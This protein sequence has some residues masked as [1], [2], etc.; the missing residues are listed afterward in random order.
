MTFIVHFKDGHRQ[1]YS[2]RYDEDIE[3]ERDAAW[4]DVYD[5]SPDA[6]YIESF[7]YVC[8]ECMQSENRLLS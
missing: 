2:N 6:D 7:F 4:D 5:A 3:H 8:K 1:S